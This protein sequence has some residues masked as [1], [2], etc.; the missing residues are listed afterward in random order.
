[1]DNVIPETFKKINELLAD[2]T[3]SH[4]ASNRPAAYKYDDKSALAARQEAHAQL[5]SLIAILAEAAKDTHWLRLVVD[6]PGNV[7]QQYFQAVQA[8]DHFKAG[9]HLSDLLHLMRHPRIFKTLDTTWPDPLSYPTGSSEVTLDLGGFTM[10]GLDLPGENPPG[11]VP[12]TD[13]TDPLIPKVVDNN[14]LDVKG[15][16]IDTSFINQ[17]MKE[18]GFKSNRLDSSPASSGKQKG[19]SKQDQGAEEKKPAE[20]SDQSPNSTD[21]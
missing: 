21:K 1:M 17:Q 14:T 11:Y 4:N 13:N 9:D 2:L 15:E 18:N 3:K 19:K 6:A 7:V 5:N 10:G 16:P 20:K 8:N 12:P